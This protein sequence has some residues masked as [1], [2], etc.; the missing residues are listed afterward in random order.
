MDTN[1]D[2]K[3]HVPLETD[4]NDTE[5][6]MYNT[7][8]GLQTESAINS[9]KI[10][11][12]KTSVDDSSTKNIKVV[13]KEPRRGIK[14]F[15]LSVLLIATIAT[16]I[17]LIVLEKNNKQEAELLDLEQNEDVETSEE[18]LDVPEENED[19]EN[20]IIVDEELD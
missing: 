18:N 12:K 1:K 8:G 19:I 14:I 2:D 7:A 15:L 6:D 10:N 3:S 13:D 4:V 11:V 9:S 20:E 17:T 16:T 5:L